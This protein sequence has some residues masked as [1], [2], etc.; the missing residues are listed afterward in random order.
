MTKKELA[1][2]FTPNQSPFTN[3]FD[4]VDK[5]L[6]KIVC[7]HISEEDWEQLDDRTIELLGKHLLNEEDKKSLDFDTDSFLNQMNKSK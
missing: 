1:Q 4:K 2:S 3:R 7:E 6:L 5:E